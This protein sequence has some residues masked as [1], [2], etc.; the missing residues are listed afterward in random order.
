M[1]VMC[2]RRG[3]LVDPFCIGQ[4]AGDN[5]S[6]PGVQ[7][8]LLSLLTGGHAVANP[9]CA[10]Q[11][12]PS[13][14]VGFPHHVELQYAML[15]VNAM[16]KISITTSTSAG[17]EQILPQLYYHLQSTGIHYCLNSI[18]GGGAALVIVQGLQEAGI[19]SDALHVGQ[20]HLEKSQS[21]EVFMSSVSWPNSIQAAATGELTIVNEFQ[22]A[23]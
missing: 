14:V 15:N 8:D 23:K 12:D 2:T 11:L 16:P 10:D 6:L 21:Q 20:T 13:D 1:G 3:G 18:T 5:S 9:D 4:L 7:L 17:L 22:A 19:F